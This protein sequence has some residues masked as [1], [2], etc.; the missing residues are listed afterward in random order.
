MDYYVYVLRSEKD[1]NIY[2]GINNNLDRRLKQ[3]NSGKVNSTK[4][5]SPFKLIHRELFPSRKSAREREKYLKSG[6]GRELI[7]SLFY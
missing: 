6:F 4:H 3:H 5:R 7:K 2:I 1:D